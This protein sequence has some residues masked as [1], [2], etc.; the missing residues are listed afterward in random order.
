MSLPV[1]CLSVL[2]AALGQAV[3]EALAGE[4]LKQPAVQK[5]IAELRVETAPWLRQ[6]GS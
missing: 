3:G 1:K 6:K 2:L 5:I 4:L